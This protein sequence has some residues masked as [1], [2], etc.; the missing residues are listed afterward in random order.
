MTDG[1][2][3]ERLKRAKMLMQQN[4]VPWEGWS[5]AQ[6]EEYSNGRLRTKEKVLFETKCL[7]VTKTV[8]EPNGVER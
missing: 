2:T 7:R 4:N 8:V 1:P 6:I 5:S 3:I